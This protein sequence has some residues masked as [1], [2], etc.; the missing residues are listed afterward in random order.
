M[1]KYRSLFSLSKTQNTAEIFANFF[2]PKQKQDVR[3]LQPWDIPFQNIAKQTI[4]DFSSWNFLMQ[5]FKDKHL[6]S[7]V[8]ILK[9]YLN[10]TFI[11][12]LQLHTSKAEGEK[13]NYFVFNADKTKIS[14]DTGLQNKHNVDLIAV[15]GKFD[16]SK[17]K[18]QSQLSSDDIQTT[19]PDWVFQDIMTPLSDTYVQIFGGLVPDIAWYTRDS[20]EYVYDT[21]YTINHE[22]HDHLLIRAKERSG[23]PTA[24]DEAVRTYLRGVIAGIVPKILRNYKIAI[25]MFY[26]ETQIMQLLLP[27]EA[28]NGHVSCLLVS[29]DDAIRQYRIKTILDMD[30]A[31][32]AARLITRPDRDWLRP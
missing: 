22:V 23:M 30:Q 9:N 18:T 4:D 21:N 29:R 8:P 11:R 24:S 12:L 2:P 26:K 27:Y 5:N 14:F 17:N 6:Y 32:F 15:F 16:P 31:Y 3:E 13:S 20:R 1:I 19:L 10:Y 28:I 7:Q 25:P